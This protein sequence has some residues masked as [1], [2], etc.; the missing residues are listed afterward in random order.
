M[1][2]SRYS[3]ASEVTADFGDVTPDEL[4]EVGNDG[5]AVAVEHFPVDTARC[6][7]AV[8]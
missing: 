4:G 6:R 1:R 2:S 5:P 7:I 3:N 8:L